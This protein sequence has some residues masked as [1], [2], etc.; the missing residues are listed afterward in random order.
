M[1]SIILNDL[2]RDVNHNTI[3]HFFQERS[4]LFQRKQEALTDYDHDQFTQGIK[5]G[6][7][8]FG[9]IDHM[10]VCAFTVTHALSERSGKK[11]QYDLA[12]KIIRDMGV[13]AGIFVFI[14][15]N[16][17]FRFSLIYANYLGTKVD[18]SSF[19]R[20]TYFVSPQLTNKTFIQR[21]GE[22]DFSAL[23]SIKEVFSV[24]KVTKEFYQ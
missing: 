8:P 10:I 12:K 2:I 4:S 23:E 13:D 15:E 20:F 5:L 19:R 18:Y 1:T 6:E 11:A 22:G 3:A 24:E 17:A 21:V 14:G 16:G 7:I 9:L